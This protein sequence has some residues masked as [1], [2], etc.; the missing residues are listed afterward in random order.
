MIL[1]FSRLPNTSS[2]ITFFSISISGLR[3]WGEKYDGHSSSIKYTDKWAECLEGD[4]WTKWGDKWDENFNQYGQ[5]V[6]Q[7][8]MWWE[9]KYGERWNRTSGEGHNGSGWVHKDGDII[10]RVMVIIHM[11]MGMDM[12]TRLPTEF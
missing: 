3:R 12:S 10:G 11:G 9:G 4:G 5:G 2:Q 1:A 7:G 8:E 6:K